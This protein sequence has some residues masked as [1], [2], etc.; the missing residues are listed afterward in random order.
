LT[1]EAVLRGHKSGLLTI[2][3]YNNL[4]QCE[5]LD[6]IK[7]NLVRSSSLIIAVHIRTAGR[8]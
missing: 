4:C 1:A 8:A 2:S 6:D 7:L 5:T 3:D